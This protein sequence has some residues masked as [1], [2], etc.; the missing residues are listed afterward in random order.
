M[1]TICLIRHGATAGNLERRYIGATDEPLCPEGIA[2]LQAM[3]DRPPQADRLFVSPM[4]RARQTAQ[5][6]FPGMAFTVV[7]GLRETDF[8]RFEGRTGTEL[9]AD[10]AYRAWVD[11][12][13]TGDIPEGE[14]PAAFKARCTAAF[15]QAA[16]TLMEG[17]RAAFVVHGGVIMAILERFAEGN[18]YDYHTGNGHWIVCRYEGGA[19]HI[20][21]RSTQ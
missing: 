14:S 7:D 8:G 18:F 12:G 11:G 16:D 15:A 6:Y 4:L 9:W 20:E 1:N 10:P 17:E 3:G 21:G 19:L 5:L 2:R 13:C